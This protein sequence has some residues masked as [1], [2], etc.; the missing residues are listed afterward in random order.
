LPGHRG[1]RQ[2]VADEVDA[3]P[4]EQESERSPDERQDCSF[5]DGL[6]RN[7]P[8]ARANGEAYGDLAAFSRGAREH[9]ARNIQTRDQEHESYRA[10]QEEE[11]RSDFADDAL[12]ER[13]DG[14]DEFRVG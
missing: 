10:E 4:R 3:S 9:Q 1:G 2:Q 5:G 8:T 13:L 11:H 12:I 6:A 14:G 7:V